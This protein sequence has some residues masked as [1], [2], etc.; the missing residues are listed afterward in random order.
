MIIFWLAFGLVGCGFNGYHKAY[1]F[2]AHSLLY[3][4]FMS[5]RIYVWY[6]ATNLVSHHTS[7]LVFD[8]ISFVHAHSFCHP[9]NTVHPTTRI[10][11][12]IP[13]KRVF[14]PRGGA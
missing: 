14:P 10:T 2:G 4:N 7:D 1:P 8:A 13:L 5:L 12:K 3:E 6:C 9:Q 11:T